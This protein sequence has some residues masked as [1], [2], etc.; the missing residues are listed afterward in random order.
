MTPTTERARHRMRANSGTA[1][2]R[3][4]TTITP[5]RIAPD[6]F[7]IFVIVDQP[8]FKTLY[9]RGGIVRPGKAKS[10]PELPARTQEQQE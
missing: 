2:H 9:K 7:I 4:G 6:F 8:K 5:H 3:D 1:S 10:T